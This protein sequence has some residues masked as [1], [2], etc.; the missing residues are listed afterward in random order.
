MSSLWSC[1]CSA[2]WRIGLAFLVIAGVLLTALQGLQAG[3]PLPPAALPQAKGSP[4]TAAESSNDSSRSAKESAAKKGVAAPSAK[5]AALY[6]SSCQRCH[7]QDGKG[8]DARRSGMEN[9]PDFTRS[10]WQDKRSDNQLQVSI[11]DGKGTKMPAFAGKL[12]REQTR[13]LVAYIRKFNPVAKKTAR[14]KPDDFDQA[15][16]ELERE[17]QALKEQARKSQGDKEKP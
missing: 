12:S 15:W 6:R 4:A 14:E 3:D 16:R 9:I 8:G 11:F 5:A 2:H 10:T 1:S 17:L 7:A 13:D